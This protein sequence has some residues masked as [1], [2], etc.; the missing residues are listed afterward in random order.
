MS[1]ELTLSQNS[2]MACKIAIKIQTLMCFVE[3]HF[4][5]IV[6]LD[7]LFAVEKITGKRWTSSNKNS[8]W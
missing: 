4:C 1:Q 8:S 6:G 5:F 2:Q 7:V 3:Q